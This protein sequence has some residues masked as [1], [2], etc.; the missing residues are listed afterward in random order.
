MSSYTYRQ[1]TKCYVR[2][3]VIKKAIEMLTTGRSNSCCVRNSYMIGFRLFIRFQKHF[4]IQ[5]GNTRSVLLLT[6]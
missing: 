5:V 6:D 2:H 1:E 3:T 4:Q